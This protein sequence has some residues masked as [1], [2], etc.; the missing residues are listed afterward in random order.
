MIIWLH[1]VTVLV[2]A[3]AVLGLTLFFM[4]SAFLYRPL[5]E[6]VN[7]PED[8]G[9]EFE[10]VTLE[11]ADGVKLNAWYIP[12][13]EAKMTML[14]CHGNG[15][16]IM[17][18]LDS[19]NLFNKL[20]LN[21]L[22]FDY[23]GYGQSEGKPTE[24]GT[25]TDAMSAYKWLTQTKNISPDEIIVFGRSLGGSVAA[26]IAERMKV[27]A[28]VLESCF[29]SYVDVGK[30]FYPYM[31]VRWFARFKYDTIDSLKN[32]KCPV[33]V[34]HSRS[35]EMVPFEFGLGLYD[36]A[37]EPKEFVEIAGNHNDGFLVS[38]EIYTVA[39]EKWLKFLSERKQQTVHQQELN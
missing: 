38:G 27:R 6:I 25:Y 32:V 11:T 39:W 12:A 13:K 28:L 37:P 19:I 14:F 31:P 3:Y 7:T 17:H 1:I 33:M 21:C 22:I 30:K 4:Q 9:I 35:D 8:I 5:R 10:N 24:Q 34:I 16:N 15:G 2:I 18:R 29:T 20:G 36:V 26:Y 23:R